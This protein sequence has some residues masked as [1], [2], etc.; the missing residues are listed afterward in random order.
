MLEPETR[1]EQ[2]GMEKFPHVYGPINK[3]AVNREIEV[4]CNGDGLF[5]GA[6]DEL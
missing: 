3:S 5:W 1:Y 6:F 2:N 4:Q